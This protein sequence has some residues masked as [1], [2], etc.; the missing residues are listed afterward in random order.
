MSASSVT[1]ELRAA[2]EQLK[3]QLALESLSADVDE[4]AEHLCVPS[5]TPQDEDV[6]L[7]SLGQQ[8]EDVDHLYLPSLPQD[9]DDVEHL[10]LLPPLTQQDDDDEDW[11]LLGAG[12]RWETCALVL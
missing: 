5:L 6:D 11:E 7:P 10:D 1:D 8:D 4:H 9:E 12:N 2:V 3:R